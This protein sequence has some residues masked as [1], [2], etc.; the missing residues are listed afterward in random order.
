M[1]ILKNLS[2]L[3]HLGKGLCSVSYI[4]WK[5]ETKMPSGSLIKIYFALNLY[6]EIISRVLWPWSKFWLN[7]I[8]L[9]VIF[10]SFQN[11]QF[12]INVIFY[13]LFNFTIWL[14]ILRIRES[15]WTC[16]PSQFEVNILPVLIFSTIFIS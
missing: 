10:K 13:L 5:V 6:I 11:E 4:D 12:K 8:R 3:F 14:N 9:R 2:S 7:E 16:D 15:G 1:I